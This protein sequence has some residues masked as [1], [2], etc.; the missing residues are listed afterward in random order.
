MQTYPKLHK[1][2]PGN[3]DLCT[4][5]ISRAPGLVAPSPVPSFQLQVTIFG[6]TNLLKQ[7]AVHLLEVR[8]FRL[9]LILEGISGCLFGLRIRKT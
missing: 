2:L 5:P 6:K 3:A 1:S 4:C 9:P 8:Q 7:I